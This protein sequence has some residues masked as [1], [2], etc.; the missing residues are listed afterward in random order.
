MVSLDINENCYN[1]KSEKTGYAVKKYFPEL[2]I[3]KWQLFKGRQPRVFLSKLKMKFDFLFLDTV[4]YAPGEMINLLEVLPFLEENTI[5]V[6]HD[7]IYHFPS[8]K[9]YNQKDI[10][11]HPSQIYLISSLMGEKI[12]LTSKIII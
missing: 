11:I 10:K 8:L 4:H 3:N 6:L 5:I 1:N 9:Y 7:I 12:I 2:A